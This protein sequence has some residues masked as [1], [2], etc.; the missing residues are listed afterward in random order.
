[1]HYANMQSLYLL[2]VIFVATQLHQ[3]SL[4]L[5]NYPPVESATSS[6]L[7]VPC[8]VFLC[9]GS[10]KTM[11]LMYFKRC[12]SKLLSIKTAQTFSPGLG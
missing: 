12:K 6:R 4:I 11:T 3:K 5:S 10:D 1:M 9:T 8:C 7:N 2:W